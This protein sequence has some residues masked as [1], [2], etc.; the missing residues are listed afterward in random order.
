M[1]DLNAERRFLS[2]AGFEFTEICQSAETERPLTLVISY[3]SN[4][5]EWADISTRVSSCSEPSI[6]SWYPNVFQVLTT[7][8]GA[9]GLMVNWGTIHLETISEK[10]KR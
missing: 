6:S 3:I 10:E 2:T 4:P 8:H 9:F 5:D 7:M 1:H